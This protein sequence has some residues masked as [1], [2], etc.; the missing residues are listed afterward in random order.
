MSLRT[1]AEWRSAVYRYHTAGT[2]LSEPARVFLL[3]LADH[4]NAD[5]TVKRS[6][7]L[8]AADL[9]VAPPTVKG[10]VDQAIEAGFLSR[11]QRGQKDRTTAVYQGIFP[12][13]QAPRVPRP[14]KAKTTPTGQPVLTCQQVNPSHRT[15]GQPGLTCS[16]GD[17]GQPVSPPLLRRPATNATS[18]QSGGGSPDRTGVTGTPVDQRGPVDH[19][20]GEQDEQARTERDLLDQPYVSP[21]EEETLP[22]DLEGER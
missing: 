3:L 18:P 6:R 5:R 21:D 1:V 10:Y 8:I 20:S 9:D 7:R 4:M 17:S 16:E 15:T 11:I 14:R 12:P 2:P 19:D 22:P 13:A